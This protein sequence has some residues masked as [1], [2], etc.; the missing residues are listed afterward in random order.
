MYT[1]NGKPVKTSC[2]SDAV[3]GKPLTSA[4]I[5]KHRAPSPKRPCLREITPTP[6]LDKLD[7]LIHH[8]GLDFLLTHGYVNLRSIP[9]I[10]PAFG[11]GKHTTPAVAYRQYKWTG[12]KADDEKVVLPVEKMYYIHPIFSRDMWEIHEF[13]S[14]SMPHWDAL[15][16][17]WQLATLMLEE[18]VM[19]GFLCGML[20]KSKHCELRETFDDGWKMYSF[21]AKQNPTQQELWELW[22]T[23]WNL[24][25][26]VK[27]GAYE[28]SDQPHFTFGE[29]RYQTE[30]PG[31]TPM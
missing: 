25:D 28:E 20:D 22:E 1:E 30:S 27:F 16:P 19:S 24:K 7:P 8:Y 4:D 5:E 21:E 26:V 15:K 29:T 14:R 9:A 11:Y 23:I 3:T 10:D 31:L 17:V 13:A 18:K 12:S 2:F 6:Y